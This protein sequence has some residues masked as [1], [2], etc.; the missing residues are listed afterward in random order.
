MRRCRIGTTTGR[1][2]PELSC[3]RRLPKWPG[4]GIARD[5]LSVHREQPEEVE[6]N[7][8]K[9]AA[10]G[11]ALLLIVSGLTQAASLP[12]TTPDGLH[13][14]PKTKFAAVY[15]KPDVDF[16][17]YTEVGLVPCQVAFK[18]NWARDY[19][20][21][22][23]DLSSRV[24]KSDIDRIKKELAGEC[25]KYFR[26]ALTE[27]P[28]YMLVDKFLKGDMVLIVRPNIVNLDI[29]APDLRTAGR[30]YSF[31]SSEGEMT[32]VLE[33]LDGTTGDLLARVY[34][35][36]VAGDNMQFQWTNSVTN[37]AEADMILKSWTGRMRAGLDH[38]VKPE[39]DEPAAD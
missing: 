13:L 3:R 36:A 4:A 39:K 15:M 19:N 34:D 24:T 12:E 20:R 38:L 30:Q 11:A 10:A 37:K 35:R 25:D 2:R 8:L 18:K 26:N 29:S 31:T 1:R 17:V 22:E 33:V 6:V 21:D 9:F 7:R 32:L 27:E 16:T 14:V 23:L 5:I 28:A